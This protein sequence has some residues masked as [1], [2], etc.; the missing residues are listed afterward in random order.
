[1]KIGIQPS[2]RRT[3]R[4]I[5]RLLLPPIR[6][7]DGAAAAARQRR[8]APGGGSASL[9]VDG[10]TAP[11]RL[12]CADRLVGEGVA[13]REGHAERRELGLQ[14]ARRHAEDEAAPERTSRL[15]AAFAERKGFR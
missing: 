11:C 2:P 6:W 7:V 14:V 8:V 1:L 12:H 13:L 9:E 10:R 15:A 5:A 3:A 4:R